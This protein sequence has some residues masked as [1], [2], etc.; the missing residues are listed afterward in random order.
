MEAELTRRPAD[1]ARK[2]SMLL[3]LLLLLPVVDVGG[4]DEVV[5]TYSPLACC[6]WS[7]SGDHP[8]ATN[9]LAND[10]DEVA[11]VVVLKS[12]F[13]WLL[14]VCLPAWPRDEL[15]AEDDDDDDEAKSS[16]IE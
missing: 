3:P 16:G 10:D 1:G 11:G 12:R 6:C 9:G 14:V 2:N 4:G 15:E 7:P 5:L 8:N 13:R